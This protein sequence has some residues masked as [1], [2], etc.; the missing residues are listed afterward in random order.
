MATD[1]VAQPTSANGLVALRL[2]GVPAPVRLQPPGRLARALRRAVPLTPR[3]S[4]RGRRGKNRPSAWTV[5]YPF[6]NTGS[7]VA[8]GR[9]RQARRQVRG[10]KLRQRHYPALE[11]LANGTWL[12]HTTSIFHIPRRIC[13]RAQ[14]SRSVDFRSFPAASAPESLS[15]NANEMYPLWICGP[16]RARRS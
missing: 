8:W 14:S 11:P 2:T 3:P 12:S 5:R 16:V 9:V 15:A 13:R 1:N 7:R 10:G 6:P 4:R